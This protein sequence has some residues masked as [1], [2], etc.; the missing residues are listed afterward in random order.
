MQVYLEALNCY[1]HLI[2][3]LA[4]YGAVGY[5]LTTAILGALSLATALVSIHLIKHANFDDS[6][7]RHFKQTLDA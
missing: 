7:V 2:Q 4:T 5:Q 1:G 6:I 3:N